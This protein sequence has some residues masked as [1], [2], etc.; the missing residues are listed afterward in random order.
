MASPGVRVVMVKPGN[1]TLSRTELAAPMLKIT[2]AAGYCI[3]RTSALYQ[4]V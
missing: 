1:E 2:L 3:P 4:I